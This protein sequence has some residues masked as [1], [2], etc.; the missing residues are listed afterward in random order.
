MDGRKNDFMKGSLMN[1][2]KERATDRPVI[3]FGN[4]LIILVP[5]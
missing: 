1:E 4:N 3:I 2:W 5:L